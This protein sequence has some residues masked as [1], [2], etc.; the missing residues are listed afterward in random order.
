MTS[1]YCKDNAEYRRRVD[2]NV[3]TLIDEAIALQADVV[4]LTDAV[5]TQVG[6]LPAVIAVG[7]T[8]MGVVGTY[9]SDA[10]AVALDIAPGKFAYVNGVK[11]EGTSIAVDTSDATATAADIADGKTA[12]VNG[13]KITGTAV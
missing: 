2:L 13:V 6:V 10:D 4:A 7:T 8:I 12:Y 1:L 3:E 11:L 5:A 9:T